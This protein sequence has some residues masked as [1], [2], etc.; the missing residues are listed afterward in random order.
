MFIVSQL[1]FEPCL[2]RSG[3][4]NAIILE[5]RTHERV[6][7]N[8]NFYDKSTWPATQPSSSKQPVIRQQR[9]GQTKRTQS[10]RWRTII[11]R[12]VTATATIITRPIAPL[13]LSKP[14]SPLASS[15]GRIFLAIY[16]YSDI[17]TMYKYI[18]M[19]SLQSERYDLLA[20][21]TASSSGNVC[22]VS[23]FDAR[24]AWRGRKRLLYYCCWC[25]IS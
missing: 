4:F 8:F 12:A 15:F 10:C 5:C 1:S 19:C 7:N 2:L 16:S 6:D 25:R 13:P 17:Y 18:W 21:N 24:K 23:H 20:C 3:Y 11:I 9:K 14:S 22:A